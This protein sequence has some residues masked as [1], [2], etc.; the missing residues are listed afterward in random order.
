MII[1]RVV[2]SLSHITSENNAGISYRMLICI[3][4]E[5]LELKQ[6]PECMK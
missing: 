3:T 5:L 2:K 1:D 6:L 4:K